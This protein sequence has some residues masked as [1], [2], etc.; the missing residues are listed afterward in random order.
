MLARLRSLPVREMVELGYA[1]V[2]VVKVT[3]AYPVRDRCTVPRT[4]ASWVRRRKKVN[5]KGRT[6]IRGA[7]YW[8]RRQ[9]IVVNK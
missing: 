5:K 2:V 1:V 6:A 7:T 3:E 8:V 4:L 9:N